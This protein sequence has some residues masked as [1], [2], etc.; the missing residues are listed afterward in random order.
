MKKL[1]FVLLAATTCI[2]AQA[3]TDAVGESLDRSIAAMLG[4]ATDQT[5]DAVCESLDRSFAAMLSDP[6]QEAM[7][8]QRIATR[9]YLQEQLANA[10]IGHG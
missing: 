6:G 2:T 8:Q 7:A 9:R 1:L 5:S 3:Q 4:N 10:S